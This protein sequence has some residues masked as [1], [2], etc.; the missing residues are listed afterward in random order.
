MIMFPEKNLVRKVVISLASNSPRRRQLIA[1]G[2]WMFH[3]TP[4]EVNENPHPGETPREY[5][6]RL[7]VD[8]ALAASDTLRPESIVVAAD[9]TV[10]DGNEILGK[11]LDA[12]EAVKMLKQLR[13][14]THQVYTALAILPFGSPEPML[15][16]CV[17]D[18][19]MRNYSDDELYAYV[20]TGDPLD[21]AG[22][23]AIQHPRFRPAELSDGCFAN[24]V[25]LPLCHLTR[26]LEK[27]GISPRVDVARNCQKT[28]H[29]ECPVYH[30][31]LQGSE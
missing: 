9:T 12:S 25:G 5:V 8:K 1:L 22:A 18:V 15:D 3:V 24:V 31:I 14:R 4:V 20:A 7:A 21:K 13:G 17:T 27:I 30:R 28:L 19:P 16:L 6:M 23:Y 26:S 2:G 10:A 11:P 29:Y